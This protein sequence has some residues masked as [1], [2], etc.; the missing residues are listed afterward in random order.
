[1]SLY[2]IQK[3]CGFSCHTTCVEKAP[4]ACPVPSQQK[5]GALCPDAR[6]GMGTAYEGH[7]WVSV[8]IWGLDELLISLLI[9]SHSMST[10]VKK[11]KRI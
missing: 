2:S 3:A 10:F 8:I 9:T 7:V 1:M 6:E 4:R 11:N 5:K